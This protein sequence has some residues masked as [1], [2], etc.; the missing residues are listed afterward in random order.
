MFKKFLRRLKLFEV[1]FEMKNLYLRFILLYILSWHIKFLNCFQSILNCINLIFYFYRS[2]LFLSI[3]IENIIHTCT[4]L[5]F[6]LPKQQRAEKLNSS[7]MCVYIYIA[8]TFNYAQWKW[9]L[10]L[11]NACN[12]SINTCCFTFLCITSF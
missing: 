8:F 6:F 2:V 1:K 11:L 12:Y 7:Q 3:S 9:I 4:H 10:R 5:L